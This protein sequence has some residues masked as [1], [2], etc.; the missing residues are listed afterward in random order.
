MKICFCIGKLS[1][2]GAENVIRYLAEGLLERNH[3]VSVILLEQMPDEK[4]M[5]QK[6]IIE[7]AIVSESGFVNVLRRIKAI[8]KSLKTIKP[9]VFVIF[10][11]AMAFT[12][13]PASLNLP[14]LKTIVCER[15]PPECVPKE[16]TRKCARDFLF[17]FADVCVS[18]TNIIAEYF[19][20][21]VKQNIVIPNPIRT[22]GKMCPDVDKRDKVFVTVAR[23]DD[24]QKNQSMMIRAFAY[25]VEKHPEYKLH[26]LGD[27]PDLEK[28]KKL[29]T[30]LGIQTQVK[31]CG[32]VT[33][34]LEYIKNCRA[35]LLSSNYEGMPNALIEAMSIGLPCI[36]TDCVG[37][38]ASELIENN[39]NG[40]LVPVADELLFSDAMMKLIEDDKYCQKLGEKAFEINQTLEGSEIISEWERVCDSVMRGQ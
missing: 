38:A 37:G 35:F 13:V 5:I 39:V 23:L 2:S 17:H 14:W 6:L 4:D 7:N 21:I 20:R 10:N 22:P 29:V 1:F 34:P 27:G 33:E 36:S 32:N 16:K 11:Y 25:V 40:I 28:Y 3:S 30:D 18:Q 9:D 24:Y 19:K 26:F 15:N 12:A 8:R 31:F